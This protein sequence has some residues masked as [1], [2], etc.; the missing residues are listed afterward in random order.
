MAE[1]AT[2]VAEWP[3]DRQRANAWFNATQWSYT[4]NC[5]WNHDSDNQVQATRIVV[6]E[7]R[8][9]QDARAV[10]E[11][12]YES[13]LRYVGLHI[14]DFTDEEFDEACEEIARERLAEGPQKMYNID[15]LPEFRDIWRGRSARVMLHP[16]APARGPTRSFD[17][18][19][20]LRA[21]ARD[22]GTSSRN[23]GATARRLRAR[24]RYRSSSVK[25]SADD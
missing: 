12:C 17:H 18:G 10:C 16:S 24:S 11:E 19:H 15:D 9:V 6:T 20:A 22:A 23:A 13:V 2:L 4:G 1:G 21:V 8:G 3:W 5:A 25:F 7:L 14:D